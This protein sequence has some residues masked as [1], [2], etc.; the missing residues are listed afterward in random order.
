MDSTQLVTIAVTA[1]ITAFVKEIVGWFASRVKNLAINTTVREKIKKAFTVNRIVA[2]IN[3]LLMLFASS[4]VYKYVYSPNPVDRFAIF[5][6]AFYTCAAFANL[7]RLEIQVAL[8]YEISQ[9]DK[10]Q[11]ALIEREMDERHAAEL[12]PLDDAI[13]RLHKKVHETN[14]LVHPKKELKPP[15]DS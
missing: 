11:R 3:L 14:H 5:N 12:K 6:I 9:R 8:F 4:E 7:L 15:K 1:I 10:I 13:E 2:I